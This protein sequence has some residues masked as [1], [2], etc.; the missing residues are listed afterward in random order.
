MDVDSNSTSAI[1]ASSNAA[2]TANKIQVRGTVQK[3]GNAAFNPSPVTGSASFADP[4]SGLTAP[5]YGSASPAVSVS[6]NS[7]QTLNPGVYTSIAVSGNGSLTLNPGTYV[8]TTGGFTV[9]ANGA[10]KGSGVTIYDAGGS[11]NLS[12][13]GNISLTAP[14]TGAY[15]G[16]LFFQSRTNS[17]VITLSSNGMVI[18]GGLIYAPDAAIAISGNGQFKGSLIV[19]TVNIS[20]NSVLNQLSSNGATV[21]GP[22]QIR[23]AYGVNNLPLDGTG[24]TIAIVDA[25]DNPSIYQS[26]DA[27]DTEFSG[28]STSTSLL[29]QYGPASS[30]LTVVN[31]QGQ[32][33][34]LPAA[35]PSGA[36]VANWEMEE[37][38]DVEW[39]HATAP[40]A[41]IILVEANSQSLSDLMTSVA[42]AA[43]QPGVSVVSMS[44]GFTEGQTVLAQD[45]A[46]YDKDLT[47]WPA[48][49]G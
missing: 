5:S 49:R 12:G 39:I 46:Q 26:V 47:T 23:T 32:T 18:P 48:T 9:S 29:Q 25:Y 24:Q 20:S 15:A 43:S 34:N 7:S 11:I 3:S 35:D 36:G 22:Q 19:N 1:A 4:L 16:V 31:Q 44:W 13:N 8:I 40:G 42:T 10:V 45:E 28:T 14:T 2:V 33:T 38:L 27:F 37:A 30:F 17:N 41:N 6:G 21:Y